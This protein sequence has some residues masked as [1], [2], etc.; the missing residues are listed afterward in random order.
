MEGLHEILPVE[1]FHFLTGPAHSALPASV[2]TCP[3]VPG[4]LGC[5]GGF[6]YTVGFK[7][8]LYPQESQDLGNTWTLYVAQ[9][10]KFLF[11]FIIPY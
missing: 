8:Q 9:L 3:A 1:G 4:S 2:L 10:N 5:E 11:I 7:R 6:L